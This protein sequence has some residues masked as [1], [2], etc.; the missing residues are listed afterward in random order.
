MTGSG[1]ST[2]TIPMPDEDLAFLRAYTSAQGISPEAFLAR[3]AR[4][5]RDHLE[6]PLH[7]DV[8]AATGIVSAH[9]AG[10]EAHRD[11]F[12]RRHS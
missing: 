7:H 1:M 3:Q 8:A 5:L 6:R 9:V 4:N 12:E 2:I 10:G 11:S